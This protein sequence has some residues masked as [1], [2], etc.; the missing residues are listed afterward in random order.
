MAPL[1]ASPNPNV[2]LVAVAVVDVAVVRVDVM[3]DVVLVCVADVVVVIDVA[4]TEAVRTAQQGSLRTQDRASP[5][6]IGQ[7]DSPIFSAR[8]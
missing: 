8:I 5:I 6:P 4:L 3:D 2:V 1:L 7:P